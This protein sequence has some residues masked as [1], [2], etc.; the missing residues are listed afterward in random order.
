MRSYLGSLSEAKP[1]VLLG[2]LNVAHL[3]ADIWNVDA[4]HIPKSA[5]TTPQ[6]RAAVRCVP[7]EP[8]A[9]LQHCTLW[10]PEAAWCLQPLRAAPAPCAR[11]RAPGARCLHPACVAMRSHPPP[12]QFAEMLG[13]GAY[14][15]CF[16][17]LWPDATG[18]F[19]Y[20]STRSGNQHLNRGLRL[21]Y[22]VGSSSLT[23]EVCI[24]EQNMTW[25]SRTEHDMRPPSCDWLGLTWLDLAWL[26]LAWLGLA[27]LDLT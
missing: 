8:A 25:Q 5:G 13:D 21:D 14:V 18:C 11:S 23:T 7:R 19:S 12:L 2:D 27:W 3:D 6:E 15:D 17:H 26:G 20:W 9:V 16:R 22:A 24:A 4:K 1:V 10:L